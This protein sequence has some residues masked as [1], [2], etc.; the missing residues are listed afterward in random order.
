MMT[1][2]G[3]QTASSEDEVTALAG[4]NL[5]LRFCYVLS[6]P[7]AVVSGRSPEHLRFLCGERF[8]GQEVRG[9]VRSFQHA[10]QLVPSPKMNYQN[11]RE[12]RRMNPFDLG[13]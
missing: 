13:S 2:P 11:I 4:I 9:G 3:G 8:L 7:V 5:G 10:P 1:S 6:L 12:Y